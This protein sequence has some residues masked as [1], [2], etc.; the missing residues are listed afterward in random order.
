MS[1]LISIEK[2]REVARKHLLYNFPTL[3]EYEIDIALDHILEK[4]LD[5]RNCNLHNN[6]KESL[7]ETTVGDISNYIHNKT[8]ILVANGCLFNQ[9]TEELTPLY[10]LITSF[11]ENRSKYKKEMFKY[12]KGTEKFNRY[13]MLQMLAKRDNNALYGVIG[14]YSSAIYNIYVATGIT[15]TGRSLISHAITFFESIFTNNVKFNNIN[16][17]ITF[18][19]RVSDEKYPYS[20][21]LD[22]DIPL[23]DVFYKIMATFDE[24]KV[25]LYECANII[26][27]ILLHQTKHTLNQLYYKNNLLQFCNESAVRNIIIDILYSLDD[28]FIDPNHPPENVKDK[29]DE[30]YMIFKEWCY[31]RYIVVDKIDRSATMRRDISIIT[32]T[33]STMPSFNGWYTTVLNDILPLADKSKIKLL[34]GDDIE[35]EYVKDRIYNLH[36]GE[37]EERDLNIAVTTKNDPLRYSIINI[38][39]YITGL[40]LKDHFDLISENYNTKSQYKEC[41]IAMK[42][43]FLFSRALLTGGKKNYAS[44]QV[45]QEGNLVPK[46]KMLDV[47]GLPIT[48]STLKEKTREELKSI[49]FNKVLNVDK[50]NQMDVIQSIARVEYDIVESIKSG[51]KEYYKPT[52]IKSYTNYDN[53]MRIQGIKGAI[54]YNALKDDDVEAIDLSKR[55]PVDI[56]KIDISRKNFIKIKDSYPEVY[57]RLE[58]FFDENYEDFKDEITSISIP[59]DA[60]VPKWL[61][62]FID[63]DTIVNDNIKNF[64]FESI[65]ITRFEKDRVNYTNVIKF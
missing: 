4:K 65:G 36:T 26:W 32:D 63:Y 8:P 49:L 17:A 11:T 23:E 38:L 51:S 1:N 20:A 19:D 55:N 7:I 61:L 52:Q 34:N 42:N 62:E 33:D 12:E 48:K 57:A 58:K 40:L 31:M 27:P 13:N 29:L 6:Y 9:Y 53:P 15:R 54:A 21:E 35:P 56:A 10:K 18:I 44:K 45:L 16:E 41:L 3:T 37:I 5:N 60:D 30:L 47:K 14:N 28:I 22:S 24:T 46:D 25:D 64:P 59:I 43:E 2:Y 39:S 50:V